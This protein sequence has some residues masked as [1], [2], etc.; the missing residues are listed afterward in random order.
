MTVQT[1]PFLGL[2]FAEVRGYDPSMLKS[3][4][5]IKGEAVS[6]LYQIVNMCFNIIKQGVTQAVWFVWFL[7][8]A[9]SKAEKYIK[10]Y[11][12]FYFHLLSNLPT[13]ISDRR[14]LHTGHV[15]VAEKQT[16]LKLDTAGGCARWRAPKT[17]VY[18]NVLSGL[19]PAETITSAHIE[20]CSRPHSALPPS[21]HVTVSVPLNK[22]NAG[23]WW[24]ILVTLLQSAVITL[25][26]KPQLNYSVYY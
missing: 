11:Q 7:W 8:A 12:D 6:L 24:H 17:P 2:Q 3:P 15:S 23:V 20:F 26:R 25:V 16:L 14:R 19:I 4:V 10:H 5:A 21:L 1:A 9:A 22:L 13:L 18:E